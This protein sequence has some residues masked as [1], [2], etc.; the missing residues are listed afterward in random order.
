[1]SRESSLKTFCQMTPVHARVLHE[2]AQFVVSS[3]VDELH[4]L[5]GSPP[6]PLGR[7]RRETPGQRLCTGFDIAQGLNLAQWKH[8]HSQTCDQKIWVASEFLMHRGAANAGR[9]PPP[10]GAG[11][12]RNVRHPAG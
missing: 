8:G 3:G 6:L 9:L 5:G 2:Q 7:V 11:Q 4:R 1:M 12:G 10:R